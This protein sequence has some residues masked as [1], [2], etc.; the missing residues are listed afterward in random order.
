MRALTILSLYG[1]QRKDDSPFSE[2]E[3]IQLQAQLSLTEKTFGGIV[4]KT[5]LLSFAI[6]F[7]IALGCCVNN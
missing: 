6:S 1:N 2:E 3:L 7:K 4:D 5:R